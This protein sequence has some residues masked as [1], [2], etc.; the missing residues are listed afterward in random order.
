MEDRLRTIRL[1]P[2]LPGKGPSFTLE[3]AVTG[4]TISGKDRIS[5]RLKLHENGKTRVIFQGDDFGASPLHA[6]DSDE[7]CAAL[8][9]FLTLRPGD[10]DK[11][12]FENYT[13]EQMEFAETHA[14]ALLAYCFG[15]F[16]DC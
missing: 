6:I 12:Y 13:P 16:G 9:G 10:T 3:T 7:T 15:R 1:R 8:L 5:Y 11:E 4:R 14:E 2:Y